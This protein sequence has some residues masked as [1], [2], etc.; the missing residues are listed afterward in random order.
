MIRSK[1]NLLKKE[2]DTLFSQISF[3][4]MVELLKSLFIAYL[5][6]N[7]WTLLPAAGKPYSSQVE[8]DKAS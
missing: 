5:Q 4:A 1:E 8:V 7:N 2:E 3:L 6:R